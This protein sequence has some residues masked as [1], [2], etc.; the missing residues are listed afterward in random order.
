MSSVANTF[1]QVM[2]GHWDDELTDLEHPFDIEEIPIEDLDEDDEPYYDEED[3]AYDY[4]ED[5]W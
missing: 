4:D 2:M 1:V 5:D 3:F